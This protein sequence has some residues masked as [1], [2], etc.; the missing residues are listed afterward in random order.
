MGTDVE[1]FSL[2]KQA[3]EQ[4][5]KAADFFELDRDVRTVLSEPKNEISINFPVRMDNHELRLFRGHRIQHNNIL[6][7]FKGGIRFHPMVNHDEVKALAV[8]MTFK[9]A[10]VGVPFG[11]AKG[12][13]T[14]DPRELSSGELMR[15][16]RRFTHALGSNIGPE[17]D[18]PAPDAGTNAKTMAIIMDTFMNAQNT[19]NRN[20][21]RHVVTG[22]TLTVGGSLG[23]EKATGQGVVYTL[24]SWAQE[25]KVDLSKCTFSVQGYGNVGFHSANILESL[26]AKMIAVQDHTG[27]IYNPNGISTEDLKNFNL[28]GNPIIEYQE[29]EVIAE[30]EF[31][32]LPVDIMIPAALEGQ[33]NE[34]NADA[35]KAKV[36]VEGANGPTTSKAEEI[37]LHKGITILP[38]LLAN[39]GGVTV[40]YFEWAQNKTSSQWPLEEVDR[41]LKIIMDQAYAQTS[42]IAKDMKTDLRTASY[43]VALKRLSYAY[44]ERGIFP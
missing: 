36:I 22:K 19:A 16:T 26:G 40:S 43:I 6:G 4:W 21:Q 27:S 29:S 14:V 8:W 7:P 33:I 38:D 18:I 17:Y 3:S 1:K 20:A 10:L 31:F 13:V 5:Q 11:G 34:S 39:S 32:A 9:C 44:Q 37:L 28:S 15:L 35:I 12:G 2:Y 23:R 41:K 25:N 30:H 24:Q 42:H